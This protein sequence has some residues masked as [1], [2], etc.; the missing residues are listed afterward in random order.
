MLQN[1]GG[2]A[3]SISSDEWKCRS[4]L[5]EMKPRTEYASLF[6]D[7]PPCNACNGE[8]DAQTSTS[9]DKSELVK[10]GERT[11]ELHGRSVSKNA[12]TTEES[13][14]SSHM[15]DISFHPNT[16]CALT[17]ADHNRLFMCKVQVEPDTGPL[18][19]TTFHRLAKDIANGTLLDEY[20]E[21]SRS[22][23]ASLEC[24]EC[25]HGLFEFQPGA[26]EFR[27]V[28]EDDWLDTSQS[29]EYFCRESCGHAHSHTAHS[30]DLDDGESRENWIPN[31]KKIILSHSFVF[32]FHKVLNAD[33]VT[34]DDETGVIRCAKCSAEIGIQ[35][36]RHPGIYHFHHA[37]AKLKATGGSET[38]ID[39]RFG[40]LERYFA[41]ILLAQCESQ[42]SLKL[43]FR[44]Y[45]KRPY[46]LVWLLES[47]VVLTKGVLKEN[48]KTS[49]TANFGGDHIHSF[50]A[51]KMLYKVFDSESAKTDPRANG[52]DASVGLVDI[53]LG[54][55]MRLMELLL[56]SSHALP[57]ACRS[58]GQFYVGFLKIKDGLN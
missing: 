53:P 31:E 58:V 25:D 46:L 55:C 39:I 23:P 13:F 27:S 42:T 24:S 16:V 32:A 33:A 37:V 29:M 1:Q 56:N 40:S 6:V 57:P 12:E 44:A 34:V 43:V 35:P 41:W 9:S 14:F 38:Y 45:D 5:V 11:L 50:P 8:G 2:I 26:M 51:L 21:N 47:Y 19:P 7:C 17:W 54:C 18:V 10:V 52:E 48:T 22:Q 4:F 3:Q 30:L 28:P 49:G 20:I 36:K 15:A